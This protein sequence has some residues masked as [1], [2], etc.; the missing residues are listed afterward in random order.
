MLVLSDE[1]YAELHF[2]GQHI[3]IARYYPEG[4][5]VSAGLSKWCGAGGWRLGTFAF[6]A[7]L[8]WLKNAMATVASETYTSTSAPIQ[9]AAVRA[10]QG[11]IEIENY[12]FQSRRILSTLSRTLVAKLVLAGFDIT[13]TH[14]GFYLF[15]DFSCFRTQLS[16]KDINSSVDLC[17]QLIN[18]IGVAMLPGEAFGRPA[19]ELTVRIAFVDF[20]GARALAAAQQV[21]SEQPLPDNFSEAYCFNCVAGIDLICDWVRGLG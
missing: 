20:D 7:N 19:T 21:P 12:L 6:P 11:G 17:E 14:G 5:I 16:K 13:P 2:G 15:L 9:Y 18:D 3:S 1:I 8:L 4:T 10:Y